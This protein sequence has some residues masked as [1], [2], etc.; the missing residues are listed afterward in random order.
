MTLNITNPTPIQ[1]YGN[2]LPNTETF[3]YLGST[4]RND[5]G[6]V[7]GIM[8]RLNKVRNIF[9]S[10]N[11]VWKSSQYSKQTKLKLYQSCVLS[12][13]LYGSE[14]WRMTENDLT[15][16]SVCHT[17]S[18]RRIFLPNKI[19]NEDLLRPCKQENMATILL[20]RRW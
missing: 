15:K 13:L 2:D 11:N 18:L 9:R 14:C 5:G 1:V 12:T 4:V 17:K 10:L 7:N 16:L 20:R 19:S 3:T 8:N 6:A